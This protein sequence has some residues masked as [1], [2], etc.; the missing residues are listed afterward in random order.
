MNEKT[1]TAD[2]IRQLATFAASVRPSWH[3]RA[4]A[5]ALWPLRAEPLPYVTALLGAALA[6]P[7]CETPAAIAWPN[8]PWAQT[9]SRVA[10]P[11]QAAPDPWAAR[12]AQLRRERAHEAAHRATPDQI[13]AIREGAH[14]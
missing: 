4:T 10:T 7:D 1:L 9:A 8:R 14:A 3:P 12:A 6:D 13:R 2:Q 11:Q 5:N